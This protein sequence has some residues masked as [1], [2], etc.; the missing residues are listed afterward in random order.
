[1]KRFLVLSALLSL[2]AGAH[3]TDSGKKARCHSQCFLCETR[4]RHSKMDYQDCLQVCLELKRSCCIDCGAGPG[5]KTT[6]SCT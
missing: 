4:C 6:C 1:M 3:V 5:P 2:G